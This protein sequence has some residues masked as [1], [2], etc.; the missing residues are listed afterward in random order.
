MTRAARRHWGLNN[1]TGYEEKTKDERTKKQTLNA[2][3]NIIEP[4]ISTIIGQ[5]T[6]E[7]EDKLFDN[8]A[9]SSTSLKVLVTD[10]VAAELGESSK[11]LDYSLSGFE[12]VRPGLNK[13]TGARL[14]AGA[15]NE[16]AIKSRVGNFENKA[17]LSSQG[18]K[19]SERE[20]NRR[21][22]G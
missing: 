7:I 17:K 18:D 9:T 5:N 10:G 3:N 20:S 16:A 22:G 8:Q 14:R 6:T 15:N 1:K 11:P 13:E 4:I 21:R 12:V 2:S 19:A